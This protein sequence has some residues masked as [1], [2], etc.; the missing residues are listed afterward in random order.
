M[1]TL[2]LPHT[3]TL[4]YDVVVVIMYRAKCFDDKQ[5]YRQPYM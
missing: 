4:C 2:A 5:M 3:H 1:R